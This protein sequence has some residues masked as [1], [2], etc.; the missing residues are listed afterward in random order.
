MIQT[1]DNVDSFSNESYSNQSTQ[2]LLNIT[3]TLANNTNT[4]NT[5]NLNDS[6][7]YS[8][9][10]IVMLVFLSTCLLIFIASLAVICR[11]EIRD[12]CKKRTYR[13]NQNNL[14]QI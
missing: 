10:S 7:N 8:V 3:K 6:D 2:L 4:T 9:F 13:A 11:I 5:T 12:Q 1:L 14:Q